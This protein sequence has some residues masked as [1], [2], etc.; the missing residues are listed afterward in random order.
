[1]KLQDINSEDDLR[2]WLREQAPVIIDVEFQ[3]I[4]PN[5]YGSTIGAGDLVLKRQGVK[6]DLELKY[7]ERTR[8]GTKFTI[9]PAQRRF[10]HMSMKRGAKTSLLAVEKIDGCNSLFLVRGDHIP[11]RN[12]ASNPESGCPN[13]DDRRWNI[14]RTIFTSTDTTSIQRL[15]SILFQEPQYWKDLVAPLDIS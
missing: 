12:Y 14:N 10:H 11:L 6:I 5:M 8:R 3:W 4:E 1:M 7:L 13:G 15:K 2:V 9:R